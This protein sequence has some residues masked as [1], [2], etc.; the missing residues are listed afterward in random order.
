[1][2][3]NPTYEI[4][5]FNHL[6]KIKNVQT[7][8]VEEKEV[9]HPK[10]EIR[11]ILKKYHSPTIEGLP[12]FIGGLV[13]YFAYDYIKYSEP[14]L[15]LNHKTEFN[16]LDLMLFDSVICFDYVLIIIARKSFSLLVV[17]RMMWK[18]PILKQTLVY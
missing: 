4:T 15:Q 5:C 2:G 7:N 10:D 11:K 1:M 17:S 8:L 12:P 14:K 16:D 6:L 18:L 13:G 3:Y 9:G